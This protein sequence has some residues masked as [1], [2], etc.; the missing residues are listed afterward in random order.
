M[1]MHNNSKLF[2]TLLFSQKYFLDD[3]TIK[4]SLFLHGT[5]K[6]QPASTGLAV[7]WQ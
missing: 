3:A 4:A 6:E 2:F 7:Y 1:T 5:N